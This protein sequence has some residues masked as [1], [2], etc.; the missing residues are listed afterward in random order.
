MEGLGAAFGR[1]RP[2]DLPG[3]NR[4]GKAFESNGLVPDIRI[5]RQA[6]CRSAGGDQDAG[7]WRDP[8]QSGR[9]RRRL[10]DRRNILCR[11]GNFAA[12]DDHNAG[13]DADPGGE[14][15]IHGRLQAARSTPEDRGPPGPHAPGHPRAPAGRRTALRLLRPQIAPAFRPQRLHT[16]EQPARQVSRRTASVPRDQTCVANSRSP[17]KSHDMT[18]SCQALGVSRAAGGDA[19]AAS[20]TGNAVCSDGA[21]SSAVRTSPTKRMPLRGNVRIDAGFR[22][23]RRSRRG[24]R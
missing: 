19:A 3:C 18:V 11:R 9:Q 12:T 23:Y 17:T 7:W 6:G 22:R 20:A 13:G 15:D 14:S 5:V 10:A 16:C 24:R 21:L 4:I 2:L 1:A 8:P